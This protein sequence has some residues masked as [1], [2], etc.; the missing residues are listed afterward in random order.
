MNQFVG[1]EPA[2][3]AMLS[4][5]PAAPPATHFI[6][7]T[8]GTAPETVYLTANQSAWLTIEWLSE[9]LMAAAHTHYQALF[10]LHPPARGAVLM[11]HEEVKSPRWHRSYLHLPPRDITRNYSYMYSGV[12]AD[13]NRALPAGFQGFLDFLNAQPPQ[14]IDKYNQLIVNWYADGNDHIAAHSDCRLGMKPAAGIA[15]LSLYAPEAAPRALV[16]NAKKNGSGAPAAT[17]QKLVITLPHGCIVTMHGDTQARFR[18]RIPRVPHLAASRISL[19][20]R[21]F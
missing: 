3:P 11:L 1:A 15:I 16:F 18:H 10:D 2:A 4:P 19:T 5:A 12:V 6:T 8:R 13:G 20:F 9:E 7:P 14:Q 21:K 17:Y